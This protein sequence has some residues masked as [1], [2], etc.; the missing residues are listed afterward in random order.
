MLV[1]VFDKES[2]SWLPFLEVLPYVLL[3]WLLYINF[4]VLGLR[5]FMKFLLVLETGIGL[6]VL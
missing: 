4:G 5:G 3:F 6:T 1:F 2:I